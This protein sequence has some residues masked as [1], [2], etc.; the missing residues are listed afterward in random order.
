[1]PANIFGNRFVD[2]REP[3]WH[4]LGQVITEPLSAVAAFE[5]MGG[6]QVNLVPLALKETDDFTPPEIEVPH[7]AILRSPTEDDPEHRIFGLVSEGYVLIT[8]WHFCQI[9][10]EH[11]GEAIETIGALQRGETIFISTKLPSFDVRGE[12]VDN[13]LVA[14]S[15]MTGGDAAEARVTPV[16]PVCQNTLIVGAELATET[17]R[18]VHTEGAQTRLA[19]WL[20]EIHDRALERAEAIKETF[21][22]LAAHEVSRY[23]VGKVL[24]HTYPKPRKPNQ[25]VPAEVLAGRNKRHEYLLERVGALRQGARDLFNGQG[26]GSDS[27]A[28]SGTAWGLYNAVVELEDYRRGR[29]PESISRLAMYGDRA[30]N[31]ARAFEAC[32]RVAQRN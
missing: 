2:N 6:Y 1:M 19:S 17:Y 12:Q 22:I 30:K 27:E 25:N 24:E 28:A 26:Q 20:S 8:P 16:R 21:S 10:D 9:W 14:A 3:A 4:R 32:L 23:H 13:Y 31:K 5:S 18:I 29:G 11:V 7:K 15:P